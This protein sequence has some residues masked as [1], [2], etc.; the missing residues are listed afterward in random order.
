MSSDKQK[1]E[2]PENQTQP[3]VELEQ[4]F[5]RHSE[6]EAEIPQDAE[7]GSDLP[8]RQMTIAHN[9]GGAVDADLSDRN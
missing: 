9:P 8:N 2:R 5:K 4:K 1:F 7:Q 6:E 3:A